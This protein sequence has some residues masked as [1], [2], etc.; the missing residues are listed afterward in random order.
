M[1]RQLD[2]DDFR[3]RRKVL[4]SD[5]FASTDGEPDPPPSD[6]ISEE[7]WDGIMTLPDD[8]AIRTTSHLGEW[9]ALLYHLWGDGWSP[10]RADRSSWMRC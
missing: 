3:A 4:E 7:A 1:V 8:V 9:V 2:S 10:S 5:D 6:L